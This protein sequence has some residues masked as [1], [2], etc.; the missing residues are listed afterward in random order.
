MKK[1]LIAALSLLCL[2][3]C[4]K[5]ETPITHV[6]KSDDGQVTLVSIGNEVQTMTEE[7]VYTFDELSVTAS[8]MSSEEH[9]EELLN[10]YKALYSSI[11]QGLVIT[12]E[13]KE[14]EVIFYITI[15]FTQANFEELAS[16]GIVAS[17]KVDYI[18]LEETIT[19][20][21]LVCEE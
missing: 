17:E 2:V 9:Q 10:N 5:E 1:C 19:Q 15:D 21:N 7:D 12:M 16:L 18:G 14:S 4:G 3:G 13:V 6:C 11:T 8:F 20:M